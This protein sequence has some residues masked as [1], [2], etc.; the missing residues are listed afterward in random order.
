MVF[1]SDTLQHEGLPIKRGRRLLAP[2]RGLHFDDIPGGIAA[3]GVVPGAGWLQIIALVGI[4]ELTVAK[5]DY[6][7]VPGEIPTFL[8]FK[9][10]DP[11]VFKSKQLKETGTVARYVQEALRK[12]AISA[13]LNPTVKA[14]ENPSTALA[15]VDKDGKAHLVNQVYRTLMH[16]EE[17][18]E[19]LR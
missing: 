15:K 11:E 6:T 9:P 5:Q 19:Q 7:K 1:P 2:S 4:H 18:Q 17:Q 12:K 13:E 8:G 10:E 3:L 16:V 14:S